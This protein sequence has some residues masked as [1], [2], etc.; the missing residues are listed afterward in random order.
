MNHFSF[1]IVFVDFDQNQ[2]FHG[3]IKI[4]Q[5]YTNDTNMSCYSVNQSWWF[6]WKMLYHC[7]YNSVCKIDSYT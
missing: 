6:S 1:E 7:S 2:Y 4:S 3:K 5:G